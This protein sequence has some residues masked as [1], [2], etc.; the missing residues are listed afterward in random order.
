MFGSIYKLIWK[1]LQTDMDE[2]WIIRD[3]EI[4]SQRVGRYIIVPENSIK[5]FIGGI[6]TTHEAERP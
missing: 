1:Y 2:N 3:K 4:L 6:E 5:R